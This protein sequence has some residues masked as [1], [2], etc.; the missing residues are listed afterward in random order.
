MGFIAGLVYVI[1]SLI[2]GFFLIGSSISIINTEVIFEYLQTEVFSDLSLKLTLLFIGVIL[3]LFCMRYLQ[4]IFSR[5]KKNK[6]IIFESPEGS[7]SITLLA[8]EDMLKKMLEERT[9]ISHIKPK[10]F[11]RKKW[12]E[13]NA[14]GILVS[15]VNLV[16]LIKEIQ[17]KVKEKMQILLGEDKKVKV[18][19][20]IRKVAPDGRIEEPEP[21][22]PFRNY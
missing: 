8:I 13:L 16:E 17:E 3:V 1:L 11:L 6:S 10:V 21:K 18:N 22:I 15:E 2:I 20:E 12:V 7:V 19:L 14:K 5:S 4:N 9:E